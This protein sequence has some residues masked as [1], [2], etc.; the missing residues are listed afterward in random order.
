MFADTIIE[1]NTLFTG[2]G[3]KAAPGAIAIVGDHIIYAGPKGG[4]AEL[5]GPC[6]VVRD[7]G[8]ALIVPGFHDSHLHFFHSA[9][10][11]SPLATNY[12]GTSEAD[13]VSHLAPLAATRAPGSW[14][15]AQGW[16]EYRW[17]PPV[18]PSKRSLDE[19]YP[20]RPVALYS[21]DAHT[22][23]VNSA[24]LRA[25]DIDE[26]SEPPAGGSYDRDENGCLTGIIREAAAME[27]M[28]RIVSSFSDEEMQ[29][30]YCGFMEKLLA[31]GITSV[32]DM[33]LMAHPGLDFVRDD[34]YAAL[35]EQGRLAVRVHMFPTLTEDTSRLEAMQH[36][37]NGPRLRAPGFKQFFDGVSSQH[38]AYLAK[39]YT[40][41]RFEGDLGRPTVSPETMR[42]LVLAAAKEG[43]AVRIHTIGDEAIHIALDIFEEARRAYGPLERGQNCLEH[44]ENFQPDDIARLAELD[45]L[46]AVQPP[47]ITL[48]PGGPERDLGPDRVRWMW[49]FSTFLDCDVKMGFGTDSPVVDVNSMDVLYAAVTRQ[50]PHTH[51]PQ[52]G[53]LPE[54]RIS[55]A[56]AIRAYTLGSAQAAGRAD[57]LGTLEAGKLADITV[58]DRNLLVVPENEIQNTRVLATYVGGELAYEG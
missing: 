38:T 10:Y 22:L 8:D 31:N 23:W 35:D 39:P 11:S 14:L 43:H 46:A 20:N 17:D 24:A 51:K 37:F 29:S 13:Y 40:N 25:L 28:P 57:E 9:L 34:I 56:E 50:D 12:L 5:K 1:T 3:S 58:L 16:R 49:P 53:W 27:L 36:R 19:A 32:C 54:E 2:T 42:R 44:L 6:T 21:G 18:M 48:D 45:V 41:A 55:M 7:W 26:A 52:G 30:A 15:L 4:A 47:H 33:S